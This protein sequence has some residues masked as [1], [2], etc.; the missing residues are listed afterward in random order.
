MDDIDSMGPGLQLVEGRFSN[1]LLGKVSLEFRL[2]GMSIFHERKG[3]E[4]YLY[5]AFSHQGT[6]KVLRHGS[7][8][9]TCKQHHACLSFVAFT[10]CRHHSN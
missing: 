6:Y 7:H 5:S 1:F 4:E 3:K 8:S 10:R 9:F 2:H